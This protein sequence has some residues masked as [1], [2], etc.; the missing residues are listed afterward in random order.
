ME[1]SF[2][3]S[4]LEKYTNISY[5]IIYKKYNEPHRYYHNWNHIIKMLSEFDKLAKEDKNVE[6]ENY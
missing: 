4:V 6:I 1:L 3:E 5:D 2:I